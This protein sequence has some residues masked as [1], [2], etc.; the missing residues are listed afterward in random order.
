MVVGY[1]GRRI[2]MENNDT[3]YYGRILIKALATNYPSN[4]YILYSPERKQN[5]RLTALF[6]EDSVRVKFPRSYIHNTK[7]WYTGNGI[8]RSAKGHGVNA[9]HG[10]DDGIASGFSGSNFPSV[11]TM[12]D[13]L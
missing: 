10:I 1:G 6:N 12:I 9:F 2:I 5:K 7:R 3:S 8:V 11:F 4:Y 13:P